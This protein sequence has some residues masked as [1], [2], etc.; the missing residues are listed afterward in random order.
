MSTN[1]QFLDLNG[2]RTLWSKIEKVFVDK[3][4]FES[5]IKDIDFSAKEVDTYE[6]AL[7]L[8]QSMKIGRLIK[9]TKESVYNGETY[10]AG[11][12]I[13]NGPNNV[14]S[15]STSTGSDDEIGTINNKISNIENNISSIQTSINNTYTKTE[16]DSI[17]NNAVASIVS[18]LGT[19]SINDDQ[20]VSSIWRDEANKIHVTRNSR[21]LIV[22]ELPTNSISRITS[23]LIACKD[24]DGYVY[25]YTEYIYKNNEW[26]TI[27]DPTIYYTKN[28]VDSLFIAKESYIPDESI[29]DVISGIYVDNEER[30]ANII[31]NGGVAKLYSDITLSQPLILNNPDAEVSI[32]LNGNNVIAPVFAESNG[33]IIEGNSDSYAFWVKDGVLNISGDGEVKAL[34]ATYSMAVW[35]NGGTVNISGGNFYNGGD[36]TDLIYASNGGTVNISGGYF[37]CALNSGNTPGTSNKRSTLN[38][39]DKDRDTTNINVTGGI[40]KEFDPSN[41]L[42][43][44]PN[45]NFV[46]NG[47]ESI[48]ISDGLYK[49]QLIK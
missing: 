33:E 34:D 11:F 8:S 32:D 36:G 28:T 35:A 5:T 19:E 16:V 37:E 45:T 25:G 13:V 1:R 39:K 9:L 6:N 7:I 29:N 18:E 22:E 24:E 46:S 44:G 10:Q 43:E 38:I 41:N 20:V 48:E 30:L 4:D 2:L 49:V 47:Y 31:M 40:F 27:Y 14:S 23:Y 12:Y 15:L 26:I 3:N 42:S 21:Y 17:S